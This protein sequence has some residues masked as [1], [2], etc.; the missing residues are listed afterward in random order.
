MTITKRE[1]PSKKT[2]G[3]GALAPYRALGRSI[4]RDLINANLGMMEFSEKSG[5]DWQT[6]RRILMGERRTDFVELLII[7]SLISEDQ[8]ETERLILTWTKET[9]KIIE[10]GIPQEINPGLVDNLVEINE[11]IPLE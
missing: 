5:W 10:E 6:I 7:A 11:E 8:S 1:Y 2:L 3:S 4:R 9:L